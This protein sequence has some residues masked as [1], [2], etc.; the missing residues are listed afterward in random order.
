MVLFTVNELSFCRCGFYKVFGEK[1]KSSS[2]VMQRLTLRNSTWPLW[3]AV[4]A[5]QN[6]S[7]EPLTA[8]VEDSDCRIR[9]LGISDAVIQV[10]S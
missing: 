9:S 2:V 6:I 3:S 8:N 1:C 4:Q 10:M 7:S 5:W